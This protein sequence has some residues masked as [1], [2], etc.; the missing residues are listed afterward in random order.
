MKKIYSSF[1]KVELFISSTCLIVTVF[2]IALS[3]ILRTFNYPINWGLDISLWLFTWAVFLGADKALREDK[4]VNV[5]NFQKL[6]PEKYQ[7]YSRIFN[8]L[9]IICFLILLTYLGI[10]LTYITRFRSFQGIS[11][12][13]YSLVTFSIPLASFLMII[14]SIIKIRDI[15]K[16]N[17]NNFCCTKEKI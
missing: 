10:K 14:T 16:C 17:K 2:I 8:Y 15:F 3:A 5:D 12:M 7:N 4:M 11:N 9:I 13:S 1:C 6:L